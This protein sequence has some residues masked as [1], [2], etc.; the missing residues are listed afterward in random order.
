[1]QKLEESSP[2]PSRLPS[3]FM[4]RGKGVRYGKGDRGLGLRGTGEERR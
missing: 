4:E 2:F 3:P 1:M